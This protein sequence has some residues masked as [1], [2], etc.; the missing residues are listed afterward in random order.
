MLLSPKAGG[1]GL[2]L[3]RPITLSTSAVGGTPPWKIRA[4]IV[5]TVLAKKNQSRCT[6]PRAI[7]PDLGE[8]SF[9][10]QLHRL[11]EKKKALFNELMMPA[12][13]SDRDYDDLFA[14]TG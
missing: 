3:T 13:V 9:D 10:V 4:P 1:V 2:T 5:C 11:L 6:S 12:A 8:R 7:H 14:T